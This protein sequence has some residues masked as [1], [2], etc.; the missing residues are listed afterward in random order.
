M[1]YK[2]LIIIAIVS[3]FVLHQRTEVNYLAEHSAINFIELKESIVIIED[4]R[5]SSRGGG[6]IVSPEGLIVTS[7]H[8]INGDSCIVDKTHVSIPIDIKVKVG[9]RIYNDIETLYIDKHSDIAILKINSDKK[10]FKYVSIGEYKDL[11]VG[12][13]VIVIGHPLGYIYS[14]GKGIISKFVMT[15]RGNIY[16][17]TDALINPGNSG[18]GM[19]NKKSELIGIV[20]SM[21]LSKGIPSGIGNAAASTSFKEVILE[22]KKKKLDK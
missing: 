17:Q 2:I 7:N 18:G 5:N 1:I 11:K 21:V 8:L 4:I 10:N 3:S 16:I 14:I 22:I 6:V 20:S 15:S 13:E 9:I 19:F 12:Q